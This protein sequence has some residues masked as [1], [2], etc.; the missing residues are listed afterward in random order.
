MYPIAE[1]ILLQFEQRLLGD[2]RS[3]MDRHQMAGDR[4]MKMLEFH[5]EPLDVRRRKYRELCFLRGTV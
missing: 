5:R 1:P 2:A 4:T 3:S